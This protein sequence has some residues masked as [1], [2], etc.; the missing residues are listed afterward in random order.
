MTFI[1]AAAFW[2]KVSYGAP[3]ECW[4]WMGAKNVDGYGKIRIGARAAGKQESA[5]RLAYRLAKP[6]MYNPA[7]HVLHTCDNPTCCRPS[8]LFQGTQADNNR[9]MYA[10]GRAVNPRGEAKINAKLTTEQVLAI[11]ADARPKKT[12]ARV[13]GVSRATIQFI[14]NRK[15]WRHI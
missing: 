3:G 12:L 15:S 4:L 14:K 6:F 10:K 8:H 9:D 5:H 7:L 11:R 1:D 13:Y 2:S